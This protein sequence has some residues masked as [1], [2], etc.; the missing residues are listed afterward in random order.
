MFERIGAPL[1]VERARRE[2]RRVGLR[3]E[4]DEL[5]ATERQVAELAATGLTNREIAER[6]FLSVKAVEGNLTR[7]YRK[8]EIRSR[9]GLARALEAETTKS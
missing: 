6:A 5:T 1:W 8:L 2:L 3:T 4:G 7:V 9:G